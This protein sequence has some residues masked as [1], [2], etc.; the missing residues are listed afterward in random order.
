[1]YHKKEQAMEKAI[2]NDLTE[3]KHTPEQPQISDTSS[4]EPQDSRSLNGK[5]HQPL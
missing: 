1:M 5:L 3:D 4:E 2:D